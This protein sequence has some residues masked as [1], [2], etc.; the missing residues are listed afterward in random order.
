MKNTIVVF[1]LFFLCFSA[2]SQNRTAKGYVLNS[3][4]HASIDSALVVV[5]DTGILTYTDYSGFYSIQVPKR[6]RHLDISHKDYESK[7]VI[8]GPGFQH[9]KIKVYL[10]SNTFIEQEAKKQKLQDSAVLKAKNILSLSMIEILAVAVGVRYERFL[11]L[12]QS[13]GIHVSWYVRGIISVL[14]LN[15][16]FMPITM[17]LRLYP[18]TGFTLSERQK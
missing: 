18:F 16:T 15:I 14:V 2:I 12:K 6:R 5:Y 17:A 9:K 10:R 11:S 3:R 4:S 7:R 8:L 1:L 13:V